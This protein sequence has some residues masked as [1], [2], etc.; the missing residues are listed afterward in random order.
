ML[1][2]S[3]NRRRVTAL[4]ISSI[5]P[6]VVE[7]CAPKGIHVS[8]WEKPLAVIDGGMHYKWKALAKKHQHSTCSATTEERPRFHP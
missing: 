3:V 4:E 5:K 2:A 6:A 7:A 1:A 8:W